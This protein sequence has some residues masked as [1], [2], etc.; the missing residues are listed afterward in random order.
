MISKVRL[1]IFDLDG[2]LVNSKTNMRVSWNNVRKKFGIKVQFSEYFKFIGYPFLEILRKLSIK[3]NQKEI[4]KFYYK[5]S[6]KNFNKISAYKDVKKVL[7]IL[8]KKKIKMAIVTSKNRDRTI[9]LVRKM[10]FPIKNIV[11]PSATT[12]GKP[13]PDQINIALR[14]YKIN[15]KKVAYVGD[16]R[17]DYLLSK[18]AKINFIFAEYGYGKK[19][20][21]KYSIYSFKDLT[22][23]F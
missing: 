1:I 6:L 2:V 10:K 20:N 12:K 15:R 22:K 5:I 8:K 14:R 23:I 9:K 13:H 7:E 16:M 21:Y 17:V 18:N 11:C 19:Q 3:S 4:R